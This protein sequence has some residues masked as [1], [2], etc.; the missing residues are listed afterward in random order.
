MSQ[1]D[2]VRA[3]EKMLSSNGK[4]DPVGAIVDGENK[5][6]FRIVR[7]GDELWFRASDWHKDS[8]ASI[9]GQRVRLVLLRAFETGQ[10]AFTRTVFAISGAGLQVSVI[11]P[12]P[13][14]AATLKRR[15]WRGKRRGRS[16]ETFETVWQPK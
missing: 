7:P 1:A 11:E 15:G 2:L 3:I 4:Y 16:F 6:G 14:F 5:R 10:G 8:V 13:E 9:S 12:T